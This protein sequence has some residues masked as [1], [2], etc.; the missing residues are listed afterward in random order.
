MRLFVSF[1]EGKHLKIHQIN[2]STCCIPTFICHVCVP[3]VCSWHLTFPRRIKGMAL[4]GS[5]HPK[6]LKSKIPNMK[7]GW[8]NDSAPTKHLKHWRTKKH[9]ISELRWSTNLK[10]QCEIHPVTQIQLTTP[11]PQ[12]VSL[13]HPAPFCSWSSPSAWLDSHGLMKDGTYVWL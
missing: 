11:H 4:L 5:N 10:C 9:F 2:M 13:P 8:M 6:K 12:H 1:R 3:G 7:R